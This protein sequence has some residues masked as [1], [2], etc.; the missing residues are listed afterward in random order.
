MRA[1]V[2]QAGVS[3]GMVGSARTYLFDAEPL[4]GFA[5]GWLE[6]HYGERGSE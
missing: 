1:Y 4:H 5:L 3:T 2:E 6:Q